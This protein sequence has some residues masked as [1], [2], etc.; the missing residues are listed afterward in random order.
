MNGAVLLVGDELLG[1]VV[2]DRNIAHAAR[3]LGPRGVTLSTVLVVHDDVEAIARGALRLAQESQLLVVCGGL[4][5]TDDDRTREGLAR[6]LAVPVVDLLPAGTRR[7]ANPVGTAPGFRGRL[8][9]CEFWVVPGVPEEARVMLQ[10]LAATLPDPPPDHAWERIVAT[11][12]LRETVAQERIAAAGFRVREGIALGYLPAPGGVVLRLSARKPVQAA[13]LAAAERTLRNLL[14]DDALPEPSLAASLVHVLADAGS[15]VATAES[16]TGG[17]LG[18]RITDVPGASSVYLGGVVAYS[19]RVKTDL[20]GVPAP[21][22]EEHGAVSEEV[23]RAMAEGCRRRFGAGLA[24]SVTGIA[25]PSGGT[26]E[27]PVGTVC[28]GIDDGAG[29]AA[30][31]FRFSGTR[32]LIRERSVNKALEMAYRRAR[33]KP[34]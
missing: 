23:A 8:G 5:P 15:T 17:L 7:V 11:A 3:A 30:C 31:T 13:E 16:C 27:K 2:T 9:S 19:N 33:A 32:E 6:A 28:V 34:E 25:G 1:G 14:G 21:L 20:L 4:G 12:G 18:A 24:V 10:E 29:P 22:V 26:P